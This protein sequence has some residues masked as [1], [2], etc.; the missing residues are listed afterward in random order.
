MQNPDR[1]EGMIPDWKTRTLFFVWPEGLSGRA[2]LTVAYKELVRAIPKSIDVRILVKSGISVAGLLHLHE[3]IRLAGTLR[4]HELPDVA[5]IW[6]RDWAPVPVR[7]SNG[8]VV[9]VKARYNPAYLRSKYKMFAERDDRA[10]RD[11][12]DIL[13]LPLVDFPLVW[14]IGNLTHNG[15]GVAIVSRRVLSD[16]GEYSEAEVKRIFHDT[17]GVRALVLIEEEP[18]DPTGHVDGTF[19]FIDE[20]TLAVA[21]Y[22]QRYREENRWCDDRSEEIKTILGDD[23]RIIRIDNGPID[24]SLS[25]GI[26]SAWGNHL[27]FLRI[28]KHVLVPCYGIDEDGTAVSTLLTE[29]STVIPVNGEGIK[30]L[31]RKGGVLNCISWGM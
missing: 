11:L 16:N 27:N 30:A 10:G 13:N 4:V 15:M 18:G 2:H 21:R 25:E 3:Q 14:D 1:R 9:L 26:P 28:G 20:R 29:T 24:N 23:F 31:S 22:P 19:R 7:K 8:E 12:A 6:I 5:D 17:L